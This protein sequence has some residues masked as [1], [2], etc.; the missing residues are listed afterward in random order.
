M[1]H[2]LTEHVRRAIALGHEAGARGDRPFGA[3]LLSGTALDV[4]AEGSNRV[5]SSG[6]IRAHA[7]LDAIESA[8]AAG[9]ADRIAGGT[10]IASGEP[11]PMCA[12][13]MVW[14]GI[15]RIVFA[16][17]EPDFAPLLDGGPRF[18]L[19][20]AEV[21]TASNH[22][23]IVEGPLDGVGALDPFMLGR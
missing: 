15:H 19:R 6:D 12:A 14:A 3:V 2:E 8:R 7:E 11:C 17:A 20:C 10:M 4:L 18:T 21:I 16:A 9:L 22:P 23:V 5:T 13:G 1:T